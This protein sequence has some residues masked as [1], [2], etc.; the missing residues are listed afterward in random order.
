[1]RSRLVVN[2]I[3]IA[4]DREFDEYD[5]KYDLHSYPLPITDR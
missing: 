3:E 1:M 2:A 5:P 4:L